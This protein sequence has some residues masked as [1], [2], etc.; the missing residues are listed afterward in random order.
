MATKTPNTTKGKQYS[1]GGVRQLFN[2]CDVVQRIR[3]IILIRISLRLRGCDWTPMSGSSYVRRTW[4]AS[5]IIAV[6]V[7]H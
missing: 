6:H 4:F 1:Y 5:K 3:T 7:L 2:F